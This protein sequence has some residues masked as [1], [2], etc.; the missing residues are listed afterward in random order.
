MVEK[1]SNA[2]LTLTLALGLN[3]D[4]IQ[5]LTAKLNILSS[6][7]EIDKISAANSINQIC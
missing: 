7:D 5:K 1:K 2:L 3:E 4:F 6:I